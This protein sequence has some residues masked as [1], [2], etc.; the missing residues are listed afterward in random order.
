MLTVFQLLL[1]LVS[2]QSEDNQH[3]TTDELAQDNQS[4]QTQDQSENAE[5]NASAPG[6]QS[7]LD[8]GDD[9]LTTVTPTEAIET[10]DDQSAR[11]DVANPVPIVVKTSETELEA[12]DVTADAEQASVFRSDTPLA[13]SEASDVSED[14]RDNVDADILP[15][16]ELEKGPLGELA[17]EATDAPA[18]I[19]TDTNDVVEGHDE[20]TPPADVAAN[21]GTPETISE[22]SEAIN[23]VAPESPEDAGVLATVP[24]EA[25]ISEK[26][27]PDAATE[28]PLGLDVCEE[29]AE[30]VCDEVAPSNVFDA[31]PAETAELTSQISESD[32]AVTAESPVESET[33]ATDQ[34][35]S[36]APE[37]ETSR[38]TVETPLG[39]GV[40][41]E[42]YNFIDSF[43]SSR[44]SGAEQVLVNSQDSAGGVVKPAIFQQPGEED[45]ARIEYEL[46]LS[47]VESEATLILHFST[48]L[49]DGTDSDESQPKPRSLR[50]AIEISGETHFEG[51]CTECKWAEHVIDISE[52][53]GKEIRVTFLTACNEKPDADS[54]SALW[55]NPRIL[56]LTRTSPPVEKDEKEPTAIKGLVIGSFSDTKLT[57]EG[58][59]H[60]SE[61][62]DGHNGKISAM[63]FSYESPTP[64]SQIADEI[65]QRMVAEAQ[66]RGFS[67]ELPSQEFGMALY[68][69][70][71]K[72]ELSTL[73]L[74]TA[75][76]TV[77]ED[78]EVQCILRN[79]GTVAITP[80]NQT[81]VTINRVKLR[82]GRHAYPIKT[83]GAGDET[84][85]VWNLRRF[86]RE[87]VVQISVL[88]KYQT[89]MG[90][91][92]QTLE[93]VI[94]IR[95]AAPKVSSQIVPELHTYNLQEHVVIGNKNL[96]L[97]FV[98]GSRGFEYFT[99]FAAR[100]GSYRQVA[101]SHAMTTIRY[102]NS[103]RKAQQLR[104]L[105]TIYRLAGNSFG[106]SIVILAGEQQDDDAVKWSF[107]ARFALHEN[108]KRVRAEYRL[109]TSARREILAFNG[110]MLH[111][112]DCSFGESKTAA[113]FPGL[114]F[115]GTDEPSSDTRDVAPP[116][117]NRLVP[118]PYK[119]TVPL[120]AVEYKKTLVG[121]AWN[122][123]ETWDGEHTMLSAVFASPNWHEK[124]QNHLMG[125]FLPAPGDWVE[126]NCLEASTSYALK[127]NRQLTISA[128]IIIDSNARISDA[129][130]HWTEANGAPEPLKFPRSDED[131]L[132][133]S[134]HGFMRAVR[135]E[136]TGNSQKFADSEP[137]NVLGV[138]TLLWYDY[139]ATQDDVVKQHA[140]AIAG[141]TIR[142]SGQG[143]SISPATR[144]TLN[145]EYP[146]Y[147]GNIEAGL[148]RFEETTRNL[149][150]KQGDDGRWCYRPTTESAKKLGRDGDTVLG[151]CAHSALTLLKHA[152]I[153]GDENA[154]NAGLKAL[155]GMDR[156]KIPRDAQGFECPL[157]TP[158]LLAAA[159]AVGAYVEAHII[160][161]DKRHIERAEYWAKAGLAFIYHWNLP[162]RPAMRFASVPVFGATSRTSPWFGV[163]SQWSG[164]VF[165]YHLQ[166]LARY[167]QRCDWRNIARGITVSG[168]YQQ[169]TEGEFRGTYPDSLHEFCTEGRP[170][171]INPGSI[172]ANL[173]TLRGQDP[174][175]STAII[176]HENGRIHLSSGARIETSDK[177]S[178]G[179][180]DFKLC[181]VENETSHT[182]ITGYDS[183]PSAVRAHDRDLPCVGN[184]E[185]AE[186]GWL[187]RQEKRIVFVKCTHVD[188]E[189][190]CEV[191][192]PSEGAP[193]EIDE[194]IQEQLSQDE[195]SSSNTHDEATAETPESQE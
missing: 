90:E 142:E 86:S 101:T 145:W 141:N 9:N 31:Q 143:G 167:N 23:P 161:E 46:S 124:Q 178:D 53:A 84:K 22:E 162:D 158:N 13:E 177:G 168:M 10:A 95:P 189:V 175:I 29:D 131:Q 85:L 166:H 62:A 37:L 75:I 102:R 154:L 173:Y 24:S 39:F 133:L 112:G 157:K 51:G 155:K 54:N 19:A 193:P 188:S 45:V 52:H 17:G 144:E 83:L 192:P 70:L 169:W 148:E 182:I 176:R 194:A 1:S 165:A 93:T 71:P 180:L 89:P 60:V 104:I 137:A 152:R 55:G 50:F 138:A 14:S 91:V 195:T 68:T 34:S 110:P 81:N 92:R 47:Q 3:N 105:P 108:G 146:F 65:S 78:F 26:E 181:Y 114:E 116:Y 122:P 49:R 185:E 103:K 27:S 179:K 99:L 74:S 59:T 30:T 57:G 134:R 36:A 42:V 107:E 87:S 96:R 97:L 7:R 113:I 130:S 48:G 147:F 190:N 15:S 20:T 64:A 16:S 170:P 25:A 150:E 115:L 140:L 149:I 28:T 127:A 159:H 153:S 128:H 82:R 94:E 171:H 73:G 63:E 120:M 129:I 163:P 183:I 4:E 100:H 6:E 5:E 136:T 123:L 41:D 186:S 132:A 72:L 67:I 69:E 40:I 151:I 38:E 11:A 125:L 172:M 126:E 191:L 58:A 156:F 174:D 184:L 43:N 18:A 135:D 98:Q 61:P 187:Y 21:G 8:L 118:H 106:E 76:V 77:S 164:L 33:A 56:K 139:L 111:A 44:V 2:Q 121:L 160:T 80:T 79:K 12:S 88:L 32:I 119:I 66:T 109:S 35:E 117:R